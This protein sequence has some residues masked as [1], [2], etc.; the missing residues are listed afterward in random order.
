MKDLKNALI[1]FL[2]L[3]A[4][5]GVAFPLLITGVAA[6][7]FPHAAAGSPVRVAGADGQER[8]IG[9]ALLGQS[10]TAPG[11]FWSRPS[12][13]PERPYN[14]ALSSGSNLAPS[15]PALA[16]QAA[17][18]A[19]ALAAGNPEQKLP[20]PADLVT[21]SGSGLDPDITLEAARWQTP[22][23]AQARGIA[24]AEVERLVATRAHRRLLAFL[25][26]PRVNVLELNLALDELSAH[27]GRSGA[28][29]AAR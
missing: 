13:T 11:Y 29:S 16:E 25:G 9:S 7:L 26:E 14:P 22:R 1:L 20:I 23:V 6:L 27:S 5:T 19:A 4:V 3:T 10:F 17:A 15:N 21:A 18:R 8:V 28:A 2:F 12:A 24:V